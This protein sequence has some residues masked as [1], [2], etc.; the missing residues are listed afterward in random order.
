MQAYLDAWQAQSAPSPSKA[1][2]A[3]REEGAGQGAVPAGQA[4]SEAGTPAAR[5]L[6]KQLLGELKDGV[7]SASAGSLV[8]PLLDAGVPVFPRSS[9]RR[10][11][12]HL[13][14]K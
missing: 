3:G 12:R 4:T 7:H 8:G 1:P 5:K 10:S 11:C 6:R 9:C 14:V 13:R 2:N